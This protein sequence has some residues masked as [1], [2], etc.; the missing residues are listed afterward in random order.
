MMKQ[1]RPST[2]VGMVIKAIIKH[3]KY[4][5]E[6]VA[7]QVGISRGAFYARLNGKTNFKED[8]LVF[9]IKLFDIPY[10]QYMQYLGYGA[11]QITKEGID[12]TDRITI[13]QDFFVGPYRNS[14]LKRKVN[15][16]IL[17]KIKG[18]NNV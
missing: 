1:T 13:A 11:A 14:I 10:E 6:L 3:K 8:E 5:L 17:A 2:I 18:D 9:L 12:L 15:N 16:L 7:R 4:N